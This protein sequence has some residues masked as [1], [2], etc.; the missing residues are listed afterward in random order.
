M[1]GRR[2]AVPRVDEAK[3]ID[4]DNGEPVVVRRGRGRPPHQAVQVDAQWLG[5]QVAA[6]PLPRVTIVVPTYQEAENIDAFLRAARAALPDAHVIVCDDDSPDGTGSIAGRTG[7]E[8]GNCQV[9][10]RPSKQGLGAAY[11]H[12]FRVALDQGADVV[13]QMD[14]D[15]SHPHSLL[16]CM[17][18]RIEA[19]ADVVIGSRYVPAGGTP[20]WPPHRRLLS[21]YGNLYA[22]RLLRLAARDATS[23]MRAYRAAS[24]ERIRFDATRANGYGFMLETL[25]RLTAAGVRI[26]ELPLVFRDRVAGKSKMSARIM[27]ENL[28]LVTWWGVSSRFPRLARTFRASPAGQYLSD[29]ESRPM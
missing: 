10:H 20:D 17:I 3:A 29:R 25:W 7:V 28:L 22:R 2:R 5:A 23:G 18:D 26:E 13:V 12:G 16:P 8:I 27:I 11:R 6:S 14:V 24:L 19:G 15:F 4:E 1:Q 9:L 21:R